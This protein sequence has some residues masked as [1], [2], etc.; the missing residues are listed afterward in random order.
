MNKTPAQKF[1]YISIICWQWY[2][3]ILI[4]LHLFAL[5]IEHKHSKP[6]NFSKPVNVAVTIHIFLSL[7]RNTIITSLWFISPKLIF[8]LICYRLQWCSQELPLHLF[9]FFSSVTG[10]LRQVVRLALVAELEN[11]HCN[12]MSVTATATMIGWRSSNL[13][14]L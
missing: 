12:V 5:F 10:W 14:V 8:W 1:C 4:F 7:T 3:T 11:K 2:C 6:L 9:C 13:F